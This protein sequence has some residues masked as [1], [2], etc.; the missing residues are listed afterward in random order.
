MF[1]E[2]Q[3]QN[4]LLVKLFTGFPLDLPIKKSLNNSL[5]WK[6]AMISWKSEGLLGLDITPFHKKEYIGRYYDRP[7]AV[8]ELKSLEVEIRQMIQSHS[9]DFNFDKYKFCIFAQLFVI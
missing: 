6:Q 4:L 9:P 1:L 7:L 3:A 5:S 8:S 2:N